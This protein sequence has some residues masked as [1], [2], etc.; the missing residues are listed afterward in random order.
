MIQMYSVKTL[1]Y[2]LAAG[3]LT[4]N[5]TGNNATYTY[6][7]GADWPVYGGNK[8]GNRYSPLTQ[9]S[10]ENVSQLE[11]AWTFDAA[12]VTEPGKEPRALQ[13]QCQPI[14]VKGVLY[15]TTPALKLFA[16][17]AGTGELLWKFEP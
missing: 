13:I 4:V 8:A 7:A 1:A 16:L 2:L 3:M 12:E 5:C 17:D 11:I 9:I 15:G 6:E 14:V 10:P